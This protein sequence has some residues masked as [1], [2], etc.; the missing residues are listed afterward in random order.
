MG[1]YITNE[2]LDSFVSDNNNRDLTEDEIRKIELKKLIGELKKR[3][4]NQPIIITKD[5]NAKPASLLTIEEQAWEIV[6][7]G[8]DPIYFI[9]TYLTVFDQMAG[10]GGKLVPFKLFPFQKELIKAYEANQENIANKYRQA[11]VSTTTCAYIAWYV[12]FNSDRYVALI[13]DKLETARDELMSDVIGFIEGCPNYLRPSIAA[14]GGKD[15]MGH[16][17][18]SNGSQMKAFA[19]TKLRGPSPTLVFWDEAAWSEKGE[20]FWESASPAVRSTG[21]RVIFVSTPNGLDP[22]FY[23]TYDAAITKI[24]KGE[25]PQV[26]PI[27]L[28][29]YNDPRYIINSETKKC[30][31]RWIKNLGKEGEV[32]INDLNFT[33]EHRAKLVAEGYEPTSSWFEKIKEGYN[34]DMRRLAQ[35]VLCSFLGSGENFISEEYVRRIEK[36]QHRKPIAIEWVDKL[37]YIYEEPIEGASYVMGVDVASGRGADYT[38]LNIL[39]ITDVESLKQYVE[40]GIAKV[41]TV[42]RRV[43]QQVA[44][45]QGKMTPQQM[46][47]LAYHYGEKYNLALCVIDV[48]GGYGVGTIESMIAAGYK[49][50]HYSEVNHKPTR[51]MLNVY[52]KTKDV[53]VGDTIKKVDMI[54]GFII[55]QNRALVLQEME[56]SI[57]FED[58]IIRSSRL[59]DE[60]KTFIVVDKK[61]RLADHQ[62]SFHDDLIMSL[63][64]CLYVANVVMSRASNNDEKLKAMLNAI[65]VVNDNSHIPKPEERHRQTDNFKV[66]RTNPYGAN[67]WM[68]QGLNKKR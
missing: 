6:K 12:M 14:T 20:K 44:E 4:V 1:K 66:T 15:S 28:W 58:V 55:G 26:N 67:S 33:K 13:A 29:W 5:G 61:D 23:K 39:K 54:P 34:G 22:I 37:M 36:E 27:E 63:A 21:G 31:L 62:R 48:S 41:K 17:R 3:H 68:F 65:L 25:K 45:Y 47:E 46:A 24:A 38:T 42:K 2:E 53:K 57:R 64:M 11:G 7:C 18:Y 16:K 56:R 50:I 51:D 40:D 49:N 30:D 19:T 60:F 8:S 9:E 59:T 32:V 43:T 35:E 52:V 10:D